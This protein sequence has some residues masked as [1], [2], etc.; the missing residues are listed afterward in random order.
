MKFL[1]KQ[2]VQASS[3]LQRTLFKMS[4]K[5]DILEK[6]ERSPTVSSH[7]SQLRVEKHGGP[8]GKPHKV[9]SSGT[10]LDVTEAASKAKTLKVTVMSFIIACF[11]FQR[12]QVLG[13]IS[14]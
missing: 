7:V 1:P 8:P 12:S 3:M 9:S 2:A 13:R 4:A 11:D 10:G 5:L 6:Y 14:R